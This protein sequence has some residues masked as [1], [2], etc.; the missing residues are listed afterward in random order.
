MQLL[1]IFETFGILIVFFVPAFLI[2]YRKYRNPIYSF[3]TT[4]FSSIFANFILIAVWS[5]A[6]VF[7]HDNLFINIL[8]FLSIP[9]LTIG[10]SMMW[11]RLY[12]GW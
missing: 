3:I 9:I 1:L 4:L 7:L 11:L 8:G 5:K 12:Y 6:P 10:I 2:T